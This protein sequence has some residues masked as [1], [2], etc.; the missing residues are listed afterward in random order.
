LE[1][2]QILTL[3]EKSDVYSKRFAIKERMDVFERLVGV[4]RMRA[5]TRGSRLDGNAELLYVHI[6]HVVRSP[7]LAL[8]SG[9]N[10]NRFV[11]LE[12]VEKKLYTI[13]LCS[14]YW[15]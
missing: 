10:V 3:R 1:V 5:F 13:S 9:R 11:E 12:S 6:F 8:D 4:V 2:D 14:P 7:T 15:R